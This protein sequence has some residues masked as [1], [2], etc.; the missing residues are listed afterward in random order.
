MTGKLSQANAI[1]D[2]VVAEAVKQM[3]E[4]F[5]I[6][7]VTR[8]VGSVAG[9]QKIQIAISNDLN[10]AID[11]LVSGLNRFADKQHYILNSVSREIPAE[12]L[13]VLTPQQL[14][15]SIHQLNA[16]VEDIT[17]TGNF[18]EESYEGKKTLVKRRVELATA[19][20]ITEAEAVMSIQGEGKNQY[21]IVKGE[22]KPLTNE[23]MRDAYRRTASKDLRLELAWVEGEIQTLEVGIGQATDAWYTAKEASDSIRGK[24]NLQARLLQ[25]LSRG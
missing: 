17:E 22:Q 4:E 9:T 16:S 14:E 24:A 10:M 7:K 19:I 5:G 21:V 13:A 18:K 2:E 12:Y 1:A 11:S 8:I 20:K 25:F 15:D 23:T 3:V 6:E